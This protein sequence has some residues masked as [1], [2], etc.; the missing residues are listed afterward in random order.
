MTA[1]SFCTLLITLVLLTGIS[2]SASAQASNGTSTIKT[3]EANGATL[4]YFE[5]GEG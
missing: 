1:K 2:A 3:V 5:C 4:H